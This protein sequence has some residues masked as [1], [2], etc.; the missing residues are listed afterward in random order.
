VRDLA[1]VDAAWGTAALSLDP[2]G[3]S[4]NAAGLLGRAQV[5]GAQTVIRGRV[6]ARGLE[7]MLRDGRT[8]LIALTAALRVAAGR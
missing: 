3:P 8:D 2:L 5:S 6:L 1:D 7:A 4:A